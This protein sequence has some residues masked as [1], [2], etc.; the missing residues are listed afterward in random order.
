MDTGLAV[1]SGDEEA[2]SVVVDWPPLEV[3]IVA[4]VTALS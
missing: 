3:V 4:V 2:P 1:A